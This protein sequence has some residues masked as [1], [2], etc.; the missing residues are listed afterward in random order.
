MQCL[1]QFYLLNYHMES[2]NDGNIHRLVTSYLSGDPTLP[3]I[4]D[5]DVKEVTNM[6]FLFKNTT[7]N[8]PLNW[9]TRNV[10]SMKG[11]F[12][13]CRAFN[14]PLSWDT[15]SVEDMSEMFMNCILFDHGG[16]E[17]VFNTSRVKTMADMFTGCIE[18][19]QS[20]QFDT[21]NVTI[22]TS[23]FNRC[24]KMNQPIRF[25]TRRLTKMNYMFT[26]CI[27]FDQPIEFDTRNV[28]NMT[29]MFD[30]CFRFNSSIRLDTSRVTDMS[31]MFSNCHK[32][33]QDIRFKT[34]RVKDMSEMFYECKEFNSHVDLD[35][36]QVTDMKGMF[37][38]CSLFN[39]DLDFDTEKVEDMSEMFLDC[40]SYNNGGISLAITSTA[41]KTTSGMFSGCSRFNVVVMFEDTTTIEDTSFMFLNCTQFNQVVHF[42]GPNLYDAR[43]MFEGCTAL[44][45]RPDLTHDPNARIDHMFTNTRFGGRRRRRVDAVQIHKHINKIN[46]TMLIKYLESKVS[47]EKLT[48]DFVKRRLDALNEG[49]DL[50]AIFK[51]MECTELEHWNDDLKKMISLCLEYVSTQPKEFQQLYFDAF[52]DDCM[53]AY[54]KLDED[55][56]SDVTSCSAGMYERLITSLMA[57]CSAFPDETNDALYSMISGAINVT[58]I[59]QEW[60]KEYKRTNYKK[61][62]DD[63]PER[64]IELLTAHLKKMDLTLPEWFDG[65]DTL[66]EETNGGGKTKKYRK[67]KTRRK[68]KTRQTRIKK[69]TRRS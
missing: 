33:N 39:Q 13:N 55:D 66:F 41:L 61:A 56:T 26:E 51:K 49:K 31:S 35:T 59:V 14:Q 53:N 40:E 25:D 58:D 67:H 45:T 1:F 38:G 65:E 16:Q 48:M 19:N 36:S 6:N 18:F 12:E 29:S 20:I 22:M 28:T 30:K 47:G 4:I 62:A 7:L 37:T 60:M 69:N 10:K 52:Y 2:I 34:E 54:D 5:W 68:K 9:N 44:T 50:G 15:S 27:N 42:D 11:T 3:P 57:P 46:K 24:F 17:I 23:M 43:C 63:T 64:R 32:F 8:E 21:S